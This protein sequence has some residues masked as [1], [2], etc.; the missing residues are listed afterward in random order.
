M[1]KMTDG[2]IYIPPGGGFT[3]G[4]TSIFASEKYIDLRNGLEKIE[5]DFKNNAY[6]IIK[7][8]VG[9]EKIKNV[10]LY[11]ELKKRGDV[12]FVYERNNQFEF[13]INNN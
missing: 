6:E 13:T 7:K 2:T 11:F 8:F 10:K 12:L 4:G 1:L 5:N 3:G 9:T